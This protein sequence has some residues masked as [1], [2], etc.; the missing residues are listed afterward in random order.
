MK[1][2]ADESALHFTSFRN[3]NTKLYPSEG[4]E[5]GKE[6][7]A[8]GELDFTRFHLHNSPKCV[9]VARFPSIF[10]YGL[11]SN[12]ISLSDTMSFH[13]SPPFPSLTIDGDIYC[14][15]LDR[16]HRYKGT[17]DSLRDLFVERSLELGKYT[18]CFVRFAFSVLEMYFHRN[19]ETTNM[20]IECH[21]LFKF[22]VS[23]K[24]LFKCQLIFFR[25][26]ITLFIYL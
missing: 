11:T 2:D 26:H 6:W 25:S 19:S 13:L 17:I 20:T 23:I 22:S 15:E 10:K 7:E 9:S 8:R 12:N 4:K 3:V 21:L 24:W 18:W 14:P 16:I 1:V 5:R